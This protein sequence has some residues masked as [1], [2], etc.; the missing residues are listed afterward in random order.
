MTTV[1]F[2]FST[3]F[4]LFSRSW[5]MS[6]TSSL[7][8]HSWAMPLY[9]LQATRAFAMAS[10]PRCQRNSAIFWRFSSTAHNM[11]SWKGY[12]NR[13]TSGSST[14]IST[15]SS[16]FFFAFFFPFGLGSSSWKKIKLYFNNKNWA[17]WNYYAVKNKPTSIPR[18]FK[19]LG[20]KKMK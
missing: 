18:S 3:D 11:S 14:S 1:L 7:S 12:L 19:A 16:F 8:E 17:F 15:S 2:L 9:S 10:S 4:E 13:H 5:E 20:C 6:S